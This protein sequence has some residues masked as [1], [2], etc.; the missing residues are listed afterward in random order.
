M[1]LIEALENALIALESTGFRQGGEN[2]HDDLALAITRL[3][4][5]YRQAAEEEL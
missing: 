5:K 4:T 1:K 2:V 3:R